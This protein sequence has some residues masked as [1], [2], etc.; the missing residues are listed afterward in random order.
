MLAGKEK[1]SFRAT[2]KIHKKIY[3][4]GYYTRGFYSEKYPLNVTLVRIAV[5]K[6]RA[7]VKN[8]LLKRENIQKQYSPE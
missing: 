4:R 6:K 2:K 7:G 8:M 5:R 1:T 3:P